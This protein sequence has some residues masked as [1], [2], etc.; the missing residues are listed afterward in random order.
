MLHVS[1]SSWDLWRRAA[2]LVGIPVVEAKDI[3]SPHVPRPPFVQVRES[4]HPNKACCAWIAS[5]SVDGFNVWVYGADREDA[6]RRLAR[7]AMYFK[8]HGTLDGFK[9]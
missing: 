3:E 2:E 7:R 8:E 4:G 1:P 6:L 9:S 5:L